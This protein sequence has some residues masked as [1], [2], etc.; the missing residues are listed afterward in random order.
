[1]MNKP[2]LP[3]VVIPAGDHDRLQ[4]IARSL[5]EESHPLAHPLLQELG[6]AELRESDDI[7]GDTVSLDRF[8][9][10]RTGGSE[11]PER[12]LLIHPEDRMWPPAELSVA[13]P[14]GITLLGLSAGDRMPVLGSDLRAPP[15]VE[16]LSV[17]RAATS[18]IARRPASS[19]AKSWLTPLAES[20]Q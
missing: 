15:W 5:A 10:Y 14:L 1:M 2:D 8:V 16:V 19:N 6:R 7:F 4:A 11:R 12:R 13:T 9:T 17:G 18:G 20:R 3:P